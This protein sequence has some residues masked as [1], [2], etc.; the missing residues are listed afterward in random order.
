MCVKL[1]EYMVGFK[2]RHIVWRYKA[3]KNKVAVDHLTT[4]NCGIWGGTIISTGWCCQRPWEWPGQET[5]RY[6]SNMG[7]HSEPPRTGWKPTLGL[8]GL[9]PRCR[10]FFFDRSN[11]WFEI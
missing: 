11:V 7:G 2:Y 9:E 4:Q 3:A 6:V 8:K 5:S 10:N 1:Q